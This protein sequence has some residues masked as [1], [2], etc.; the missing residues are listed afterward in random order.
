MLPE[1]ILFHLLACSVNGWQVDVSVVSGIDAGGWRAV[2]RL[3]K[4]QGVVAVAF[5]SLQNLPKDLLPPQPLLLNWIG[6]TVA[7]ENGQKRRMELSDSFSGNMAE[8]GLGTIVLKGPAVSRYYPEPLHREFGDLDCLLFRSVG[9]GAGDIW[10]GCYESGNVAAERAGAK[11]KRDHYKHSHIKYRG[12]EIENHQF[13]LAVRGHSDKKALERHL[14]SIIENGKLTQI[15][16]SRL[17]CPPA[18]FDAL[19]LTAHAQSHFL[20]ETIKLRHLLDWVLF[21]KAESGNI[22]WTEFWKWCRVI[23]ADRLVCCFNHIAVTRFG[24]EPEYAPIIPFD[25]MEALARRI[26]D[27]IF[28]SDTINNRGYGPFRTRM[29]LL[30]RFC[31]SSWKYTSLCGMSVVGEFL[32][33]VWG[34]VAD[35]TPRI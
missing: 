31:T 8:A 7:I 24:L 26:L 5:D 23:H 19:F 25:G 4:A 28:E 21:L 3:A 9:P 10:E 14:R 35:R 6:T 12:L 18:D 27:D 34:F 33:T 15:G 29:A 22:D 32:K 17:Y 1:E 2:Y 13:A 16:E 11:V 30:R 20:F